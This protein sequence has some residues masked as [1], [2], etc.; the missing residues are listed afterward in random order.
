MDP[1]QGTPKSPHAA[2]DRQTPLEAELMSSRGG[3]SDR[4]VYHVVTD[5]V[6]GPNLRWKD[7]VFQAI[8]ILACAAFGAL[9]A[10]LTW[11][12]AGEALA[13]AFLGLLAGLFGSGIFLM[14]YRAVR[15]ASGKHD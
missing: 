15:H 12:G 9:V 14:I 1:E 8:A 10:W 4:D 5:T 11:K 13:G 2:S 7:N 6:I 3:S